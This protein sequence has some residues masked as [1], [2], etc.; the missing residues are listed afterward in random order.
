MRLQRS[1]RK[2]LIFVSLTQNVD[3]FKMVL[4]AFDT[5][6]SLSLSLFARL[7]QQPTQP[8]TQ[9]SFAY[10]IFHFNAFWVKFGFFF[11]YQ[12]RIICSIYLEQCVYFLIHFPCERI[13]RFCFNICT[14]DSAEV[15]Q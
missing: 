9:F 14:S 5:F 12:R 3:D 6:F 10:I 15:L 13:D 4:F 2:V 1:V 11:A 7:I 8:R